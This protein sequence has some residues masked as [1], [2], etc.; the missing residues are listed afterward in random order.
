MDLPTSNHNNTHKSMDR[1]HLSWGVLLWTKLH[2]IPLSSEWKIFAKHVIEWFYPWCSSHDLANDLQ[3]LS[4]HQSLNRHEDRNIHF[5][6]AIRLFLHNLHTIYSSGFDFMF[7]T[8][9]R[10]LWQQTLP[11]PVLIPPNDVIWLQRSGSTLAQKMG[12]CLT[13]PSHYLNQCW[14]NSEVNW[15]WY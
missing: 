14:L 12:C 11:E 4:G 1:V 3:S 13:A 8:R 15:H 5:L 6:T 7:R 9:P 2:P 10:A